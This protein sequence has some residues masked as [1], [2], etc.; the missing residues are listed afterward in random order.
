MMSLS[1]ITMIRQFFLFLF[2]IFS[3]NSTIAQSIEEKVLIEKGKLM[4][5]LHEYDTLS[6]AYSEFSSLFKKE[7]AKP[8]SFFNK[9]D[10]LIY[11]SFLYP[12]DSSFRIITWQGT[13]SESKYAYNGCLQT[14]DTLIVFKSREGY[15]NNS[16]FS[17]L[18]LNTANWYGCLYYSIKPFLH[19]KQ[20]HYVLFGFNQPGYT[21]K[22]KI[23]DILSFDHGVPVFGK[24]VFCNKKGENC[25]S[26]VWIEY[27]ANSSARLNFDEQYNMI[28][29]DHLI[30]GANPEFNG[31]MINMTDGSY[32]GY[33]LRK[34]GTWEHIDMVWHDK[35]SEPPTDKPKAAEKKRNIFGK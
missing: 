25:L 34:N 18:Q 1:K 35:Q 27:A 26:R 22:R 6:Q 32:E 28:I 15:F 12:P 8:G 5:G 23:A 14:K 17:N 29:Y 16:G 19:N 9:Y 11:V 2:L 20:V 33:R 31:Q 10:S 7:L 21:T 3:Y 13:L 4:L 30:K 24:A